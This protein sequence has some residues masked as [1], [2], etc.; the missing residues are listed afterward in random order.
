[1]DKAKPIRPH[2]HEVL[3]LDAF[4]EGAL[5]HSE[6]WLGKHNIYIPRVT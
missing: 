5:V 1:M 2:M 3:L 4:I 6:Y